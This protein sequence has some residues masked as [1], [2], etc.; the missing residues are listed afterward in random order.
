MKRY[1][2]LLMA[3]VVAVPAQDLKGPESGKLSS[4]PLYKASGE[5][6]ESAEG[7]VRS[8]DVNQTEL[9]AYETAPDGTSY[10]FFRVA[11]EGAAGLRLRFE[12]VR[13]PEGARF[14]VY[15][16]DEN[17]RATQVRGP[18][19]NGGPHG[20]G[21]FWSLPVGGAEAIIEIH[22]NGPGLETLPFD[23]R[24]VGHLD[25][26]SEQDLG[27]EPVVESGGT[28]VRNSMWRGVPITHDVRGGVAVLEGDMILG[29]ADELEPASEEAIK[30]RAKD[31]VAIDGS[32]YRWP[33][34]LIPYAISSTMPNQQ[35]VIDAVNHWNTQLAGYIRLTPRTSESAYVLFQTGSGCSSYV[36][37]IGGAQA[38]TL[39]DGCSTGN[40]I[41]E[42]GHAVGL[43]HEHTR[44]DRNSFVRVLTEN[45]SPTASFN[46]AQQ[47]SNASDIGTYDYNSV[48][49]Y[50]AFA[51]SV[52][53][54][55][56]IE[57]IPPGIPI[58]Q[59]SG[60][61]AGDIASVKKIYGGTTTPP[62]PPATVNVTVASNPAGMTLV[63]DGVSVV[64][65]RTFAWVPGSTHTLSAPNV[66]GTNS[67]TVFT[68]W[69]NG[70]AQTH[71]YT[72]PSSNATVLAQ[73]SVQYKVSAAPNGTG[74]VTQTPLTADGFYALNS[75]V[76]LSAIP[77]AGSCFVS[78]S[79][80]TASTSPNLN[81]TVNQPYSLTAN[82]QT[83]AVTLSATGATV[84]HLGG[85]V[86]IG[87]SSSFGCGWTARSNVNW[88]SVSP[89]SGSATGVVT[90]TV[91]R[92]RWKASRTGVVTIG[93]QSVTVTQLSR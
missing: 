81:L 25:T 16:I 11:S 83:G 3:A 5:G 56:T 28:E 4:A 10:S 26:V 24:E 67:K 90:L 17:G 54:L 7:R 50:P 27:P 23:L 86:N 36:G 15:G 57:T 46:F 60:L 21:S 51:F 41:H 87:V 8:L 53:G 1:L 13:L 20:E 76:G 38:V 92:N 42:I 40:A 85:R 62:A 66:S 32:T 68:G 74:R 33:G 52:N 19:V 84:T 12:N 78:W 80:V 48:M 39:A 70:G 89:A 34:G 72:T 64:A 93:T 22:V 49:H 9:P 30:N 18:F 2:L 58:G 82:F 71:T 75:S 77:E 59:R 29:P 14:F 65:P 55:P 43:F 37:R 91:D 35:R 45:I 73:Y 79:G 31:G 44:E 69:S 61:S 88:I 6:R 63:V 47:I